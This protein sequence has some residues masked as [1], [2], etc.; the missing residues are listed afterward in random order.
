MTKNTGKNTY[1]FGAIDT[2][3]THRT[4]IMPTTHAHV[5][6]IN[7]AHRT[8]TWPTDTSHTET[9]TET[10]TCRTLTP[11]EHLHL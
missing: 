3:C 1:F 11:V 2:A 6:D 10:H 8:H 9:H 5:L 4:H 7:N